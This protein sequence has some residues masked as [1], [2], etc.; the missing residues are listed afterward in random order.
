MVLAQRSPRFTKH[1][2]GSVTVDCF[3]DEIAVSESF[4]AAAQGE[5]ALFRR[6]GDRLWITVANGTACYVLDARECALWR[7]R[8]HAHRLYGSVRAPGTS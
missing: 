3:P 5:P 8:L 6:D 2:D 4:L 7:G 1:G